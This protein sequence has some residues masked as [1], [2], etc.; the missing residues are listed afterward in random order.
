LCWVAAGMPFM[1]NY[2]PHAFPPYISLSASDAR[3]QI[4]EAKEKCVAEMGV[5][6]GQ[7]DKEQAGFEDEW[8][9]L[10]QIIEDDKRERVGENG[11]GSNTVGDWS[12]LAFGGDHAAPPNSVSLVMYISPTVPS[13]C[14][15]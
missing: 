13:L 4:H 7:A 2:L 12:F 10:T 1:A 9:Q 14:K 8:R 5:L 15:N 6:V 3:W 11:V